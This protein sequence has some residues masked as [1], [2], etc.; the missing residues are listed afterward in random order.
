MDPGVDYDRFADAYDRRYRLNDYTGVGN[1]LT[2]FAAGAARVLEVGCGTGHWLRLLAERGVFAAGLDASARMLVQART[3][4]Q[5]RVA[6]GV[7]EQL[8][9]STQS[10]DRLFCVNALH[11]FRNKAH[12][13]IEAKR[14][15]RPGGRIM[16]IGLDPHAGL[17][18][19]YLYEYFEP[20]LARDKRRYL[21][22]SDIRRLMQAAGF[23]NG[24][25][26]EVQHNPN[27][28]SAQSAIEQGRLDRS[29]TSQLAMLTDEE[30]ERGMARIRK[31]AALAEARGDALQLLADLRLYATSGSVPF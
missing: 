27:R 5:C 22:T 24:V 8:P 18:R 28:Q 4:G 13:L 10:V 17:D 9:F 2:A 12:F 21:A 20:A 15:L 3:R 11:H 25:T 6:Q 19:W 14:V 30:Y 26:R 1:A 7:A 29:A 23:V 16:T 31:D